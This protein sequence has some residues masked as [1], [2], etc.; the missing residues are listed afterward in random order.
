MG[1]G[2][3]G[4]RTVAHRSVAQANEK[5]DTCSPVNFFMRKKLIFNSEIYFLVSYYLYNYW[6]EYYQLLGN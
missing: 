3:E 5:V 6:D 2:C 1:G 4:V